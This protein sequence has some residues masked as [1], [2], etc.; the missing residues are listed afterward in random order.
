[1]ALAKQRHALLIGNEAYAPEVGRLKNPANDVR[2]IAASL[3][4]V[5]FAEKNITVVTNADRAA[6]LEAVEEYADRL[7][8]AGKDAVGFFYYSGHGA[9]NQRDKSNYLIPVGVKRLDSRVWYKAIA[10]NRVILRLS[11]IASNAAHFV[12]FDACRNILKSP[13]RG[14]KGFVPVSE[15]RGMLIAF[16]TD[17]GET[18]TD[19]G[20]GSG[21]YAAALAKELVRRGQHHL[22]VFQNVKEAVYQKTKTQVPWTRDGMLQRVYLAGTHRQLLAEQES[23]ARSRIDLAYW[24]AVKDRQDPVLFRQ[25]IKRFPTGTFV[26]LARQLAE[27]LEKAE[28]TKLASLQ[29]EAELRLAEERRQRAEISKQL[30]EQREAD[31]KQAQEL[32]RARQQAEKARAALKAAETKRL[33]AENAVKQAEAARL[34][35]ERQIATLRKEQ[36]QIEQQQQNQPATSVAGTTSVPVPTAPAVSLEIMAFRVQS[37]L[38]RLGCYNGTIDGKWGPQ[39]RDALARAGT[40]LKVNYAAEPPTGEVLKKLQQR[41]TRLCLQQTTPANATANKPT[42]NDRKKTTKGG[43]RT[44]TKKKCMSYSAC[45]KRCLEQHGGGCAIHCAGGGSTPADYVCGN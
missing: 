40:A 16:S 8:N 44:A 27:R 15:R 5:G 6:V 3:Q 4:Q 41:T 26:D 28:Q 14:T 42:T 23:R 7:A 31:A 39:S 18:A 13:T 10:L 37:E 38:K 36:L 45:M 35:S 43:K 1:P 22:D 12:V 17:P 29:R 9:A 34:G 20:E 32:E 24:D 21:P 25:Y 19:E 30:A 2:L 33:A 11:N